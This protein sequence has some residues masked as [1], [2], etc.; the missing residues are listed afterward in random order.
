MALAWPRRTWRTLGL[1]WAALL[2]IGGAGLATLQV[3]G[4]LPRTSSPHPAPSAGRHDV[5]AQAAPAHAGPA[6]GAEPEHPAPAPPTR[7]AGPDPALLEPSSLVSGAELPRVAA[8]G[9]VS[10]VFYAGP[11]P[12]A[13]PGMPR[14]ALLL[15]GFGLSERDSRSALAQLPGPVAFAVSA[16]AGDVDKL[17]EAA[18]AAGHELFASIPM[19]PQAY[20]QDDEGPHSLMTGH[21]ATENSRDLAWALSRTAGVVGATA[22]SDGLR[23]ERFAEVAGVFNP[24]LDEIGRRGLLYID[25]RPGRAPTRPDL[26]ARAVDVV[27]DDPIGRAEID[28]KLQSL[29]RTARERGNALGLA[30][31]LR[32]ATIER[33]SAWSKGLG[34]RGITLVPVSALVVQ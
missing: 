12:P 25:P 17:L 1:F 32:P 33:I 26:P 16:Y 13:A 11:V 34:E 23:G 18:R 19:E 29:E 4:P 3:L 14:I 5:P 27:L 8:D 28:A 20:P 30:G 24:V 9:R 10:R 31:P 22:A 2:L 15:C 7:V 21:S 6:P